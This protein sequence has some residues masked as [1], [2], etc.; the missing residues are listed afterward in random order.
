MAFLATPSRLRCGDAGDVSAVPVTV[1]VKRSPILHGVVSRQG[2]P[3][4]L[5]GALA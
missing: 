5:Q 1:L 3:L 2:S 4:E